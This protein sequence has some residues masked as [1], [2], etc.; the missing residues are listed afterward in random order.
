MTVL[1]PVISS[2]A[3]DAAFCDAPLGAPSL[4]PALQAQL[5]LA[6]WS[7]D[8]GASHEAFGFFAKAAASQHPSCLNMLGRAYE[9]GWGVPR[10]PAQARGLFEQA[11][12]G[13]EGWAFYNLA[14]LCLTGEGGAK[15][16][17]RAFMLYVQAARRGI[18]KAFNMIGLLYEEGFDLMPAN[19]M[20]AQE[21]FHAGWT[22]GDEDAR[23]NLMRLR[24]KAGG[25]DSGL[26][27]QSRL[28]DKRSRKSAAGI[29]TA[30]R[31]L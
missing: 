3:Q 5:Y 26:G 16:R 13:G 10:N 23:A 27:S 31:A 22:C 29:K 19:C 17:E 15:D 8:R 18:G 2:G 9:Q 24:S 7:L 25:L 14:D 20:Y 28:E 1:S 6:Q 4:D 11:A 12:K 21:Y 30:G